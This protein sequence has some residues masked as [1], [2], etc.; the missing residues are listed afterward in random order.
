MLNERLIGI[1]QHIFF[2]NQLSCLNQPDPLTIRERD[3]RMWV[4][5]SFH[6]LGVS[7]VVVTFLKIAVYSSFVVKK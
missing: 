6:F 5:S 1:R 4:K 2:E 7:A 3:V